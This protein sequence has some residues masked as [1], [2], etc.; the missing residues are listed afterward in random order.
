[1]HPH[2]TASLC[3]AL[4]GNEGRPEWNAEVGDTR[5]S[6]TNV[7]SHSAEIAVLKKKSEVLMEHGRSHA[8]GLARKNVGL[9]GLNRLL[10]TLV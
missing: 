6:R 10:F 4:P 9:L 5:R 2:R 7:H 1:M 3:L 8:G